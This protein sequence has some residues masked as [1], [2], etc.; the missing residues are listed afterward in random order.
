MTQIPESPSPIDEL[1]FALSEG[2]A[3]LPPRALG[4]LILAAALDARTPGRPHDPAPA[5]TPAE[6]FRRSTLSFDALLSTLDVHEWANAAIRNLSVQELMGHLIA[7]ERDFLSVLDHPDGPAAG[8]DHVGS[9]DPVAHA[10]A[11][12]PPAATLDAWRV[13]VRETLTR[14]DEITRDPVAYGQP[15]GLHGIRL[16]L[17]ALLVVRTFELWTHHE[18]VRRSTG[19]PLDAPDDSTLQLM[20]DLAFELLPSTLARAGIAEH[21]TRVVLTGPGGRTWQRRGGTG[22]PEVRIVMEAVEFCRLVANR[23]D[24]GAVPASVTGD[25]D[26]ADRL[27]AAAAA[28]ALD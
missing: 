22:G 20:T 10:Q 11:S 5:I 1:R 4:D 14:L 17:G 23:I 3:E 13:A 2:E 7:V 26:L 24:L 8:A 15:L 19:R 25:R 27:F 18:D 12:Q 9:T 6:A 21:G 16:P 28:L